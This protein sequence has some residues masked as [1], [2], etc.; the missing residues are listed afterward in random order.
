M[1]QDSNRLNPTQ[2]QTFDSRLAR[3]ALA[4]GA[5]FGV[6]AAAQ[7]GII[8]T[9]GPFHGGPGQTVN[10]NL[11]PLIDATTDLS[12][13]ATTTAPPPGPNSLAS[14]WIGLNSTGALFSNN[15]NPLLF[16]DPITLANTNSGPGTLMKANFP[17][18]TY[19]FPWGGVANGSSHY[20][21]I[22]FLISG[23]QH[24]GWAEISM[25]K[26]EPSFTIEGYAYET[27]AQTSI[28]AGD[29]GTPEP[30]SLILFAAGAAGIVAF[31]RKRGA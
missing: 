17:G 11:D 1:A 26:S 29:T 14:H 27:N 8:Y 15:L 24:L 16:G 30:S 12:I 5:L 28:R 6:P 25:V 3:Y 10:V 31:R 20:L 22:E 13:F 18:P 23:Q 19:T 4:G 9:P 21:G 7:A 2:K